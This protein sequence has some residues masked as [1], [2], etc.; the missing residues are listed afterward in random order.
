MTDSDQE[1]EVIEKILLV[2]N[3]K[4]LESVITLDYSP[5]SR[6]NAKKRQKTGRKK[7]ISYSRSPYAKLKEI[8]N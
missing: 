2:T 4:S 5:A 6:P 1:D 3:E 7:H 8:Y